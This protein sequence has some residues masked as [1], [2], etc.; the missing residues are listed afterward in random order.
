MVSSRGR[1]DLRQRGQRNLSSFA[2]CTAA[3]CEDLF[4]MLAALG[5]GT[6]VP[7][8]I[9]TLKISI[10]ASYYKH[11]AI[12]IVHKLYRVHRFLQIFKISLEALK[13]FFLYT[14]CIGISKLLIKR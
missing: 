7:A 6:Q 3:A 11:V 13:I 4:F 10:G 8:N 5:N 2:A 1:R 12:F 9:Q 14:H